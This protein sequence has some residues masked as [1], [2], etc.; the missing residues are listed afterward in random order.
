MV[1]DL[2]KKVKV[3]DSLEFRL[4]FL[5]VLFF[6]LLEFLIRRC[7]VENFRVRLKFDRICEELRFIKGL[8]LRGELFVCKIFFY[9]IGVCL[10]FYFI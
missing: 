6:L 7:W 10:I 5:K 9:I 1:I 2:K 4:D 8:F 3:S